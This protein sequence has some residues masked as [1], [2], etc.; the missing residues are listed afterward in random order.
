MDV[1]GQFI[2]P[3]GTSSYARERP[4]EEVLQGILAD[5]NRHFYKNA[6][7][8]QWLRDQGALMT[9]L[10]W[11][12]TWLGERAISI[13]VSRY[14]SIL[15]EILNGIAKHGA[16]AKIEYFPAYLERCVRLW[17]VHNGEELYEERKR[18]RNVMDLRFLKTGGAATTTSGPDPIDAIAAAHRV[19]ATAKRRP[20][21]A[22][23]DA[24]QSDLFS[25]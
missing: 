12:A 16:T 20:K 6:S 14:E 25:A 21:S 15:R 10:T 11:P 3:N 19:L 13:P 18:L 24:T 7:A 5:I 23:S 22:K 1:L 8:K 4:P 17:Y 2:S 9:V